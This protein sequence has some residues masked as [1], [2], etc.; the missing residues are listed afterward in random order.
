MIRKFLQEVSPNKMRNI[1]LSFENKTRY[2]TKELK[3]IDKIVSK[4]KA[5]VLRPGKNFSSYIKKLT[6]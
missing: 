5:K 6:K 4:E 3:A 1:K 2:T